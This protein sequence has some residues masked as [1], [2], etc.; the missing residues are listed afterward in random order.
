MEE[1]QTNLQRHLSG[2]ENSN[3]VERKRSLEKILHILTENNEVLLNQCWDDNTSRLICKSLED[4]GERCRETAADIVLL[5]LHQTNNIFDL[6]L[7]PSVFIFNDLPDA[8]TDS[9]Y[10]DSIIIEATT[11]TYTRR[12]S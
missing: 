3:V 1:L 4:P 2:L 10:S 12:S 11:S 8:V 5:Q 9:T 6:R 7:E